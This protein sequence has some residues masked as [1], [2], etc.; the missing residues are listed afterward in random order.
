VA[1]VK[2]L[3]LVV[4]LMVAVAGCGA[5]AA[6][7]VIEGTVRGVTQECNW[8]G[9]CGYTIAFEQA[10]GHLYS[11]PVRDAPP[12][13]NGLQCKL[14]LQDVGSEAQQ[15]VSVEREKP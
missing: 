14:T 2:N 3:L 10:D 5:P 11:I 12:V 6:P 7:R 15:L 4:I 8:H 9:E 1:E 13:W